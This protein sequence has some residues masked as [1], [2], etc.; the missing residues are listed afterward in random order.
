VPCALLQVDVSRLRSHSQWL[1]LYGRVQATSQACSASWV[2]MGELEKEAILEELRML[3][4]GNG[5]EQCSAVQSSSES[6]SESF[7]VVY[8]VV[9]PLAI[10]I[11]LSVSIKIIFVRLRNGIV[12]PQSSP[13]PTPRQPAPAPRQPAPAPRQPVPVQQW[14]APLS[15]HPQPPMAHAVYA[16]QPQ[17]QQQ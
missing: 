1:D 14:V 3:N 11:L 8:V 2:G 17:Y 6:D 16:Q 5:A 12:Q 10:V 9:I 15:I 7:P 13:A 4:G